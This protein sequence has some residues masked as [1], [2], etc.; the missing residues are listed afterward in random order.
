[1]KFTPLENCVKCNFDHSPHSFFMSNELVE[2]LGGTAGIEDMCVRK[3]LKVGF[4]SHWPRQSSQR[5]PWTPLDYELHRRNQ[6]LGAH[7]W[8]YNPSC[9]LDDGPGCST[10]YYGYGHWTEHGFQFYNWNPER[11]SGRP[12]NGRRVY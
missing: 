6:D 5:N 8:R 9:I 7:Y 3:E 1:M 2:Q 10:R 4:D 12:I 11:P